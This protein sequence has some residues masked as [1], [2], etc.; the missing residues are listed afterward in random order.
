MQHIQRTFVSVL[1]GIWKQMNEMPALATFFG[2]V[3]VL[4][5][6]PTLLGPGLVTII[7]GFF[8]NDSSIQAVAAFVAGL[9]FMTAGTILVVFHANKMSHSEGRRLIGAIF[10]PLGAFAAPAVFFSP[11]FFIS[12]SDR[13]AAAMIMGICLS[14]GWFA[15]LAPT[16]V[17]VRF[18]EFARGQKAS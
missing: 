7:A 14:I 8:G 9:A 1:S 11:E 10:L 2:I 15:L 13:G 4:A 12:W 3:L 6:V 5:S 17:I 16:S 18:G